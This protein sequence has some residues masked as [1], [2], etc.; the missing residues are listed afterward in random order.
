MAPPNQLHVSEWI[1]RYTATSARLCVVRDQPI[2]L[3]PNTTFALPESDA[4]PLLA[5]FQ[6]RGCSR[7]L[8]I[9]H[10]PKGVT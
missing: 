5:L 7:E 4:L 6:R 10:R 8:C 3:V 1:L 2:N 9:V